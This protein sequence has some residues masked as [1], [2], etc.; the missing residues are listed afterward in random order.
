MATDPSHPDRTT[1][2]VTLKS[3]E[4]VFIGDARVTVTLDRNRMRLYIQAPRDVNI[5]RESLLRR[6]HH[7]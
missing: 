2:C 7:D 4:A 6:Q 3:G 1:L 5:V